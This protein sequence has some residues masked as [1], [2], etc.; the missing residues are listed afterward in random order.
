MSR[1]HPT[2]I[3]EDGATLG[4]D[5][6]IG[7]Y[8]IVGPKVVLGDGVRLHAHVV[9]EGST[10]VGDKTVIHPFAALGQP[11]QHVAHKGEDTKLIIGRENVIREHVTMHPG[12]TAGRG[13][14]VVGDK[15]L[16]MVGIH[17]AHDCIIGD[18]VIFANS[19]TLGGH[20]TVQD[21]VIL[22]GLCAVHQY[23]RIGR[24]SFVGGLAGLEGDLIPYGSCMGN[25]AHLAGLNIIGMKRRKLTRERIHNI[26]NAY[27]L[28]FAQEG[29]F[30][31]RLEDVSTLFA[32]NEAVMEIVDFIRA[33][34]NRPLC[35]PRDRA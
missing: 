29:T 23:S 18:N 35:L 13:Q 7:P 4:A 1:I 14:T 34:G 3:V 9:I 5:V 11:P 15:G 19:A 22:G 16:F 27:R 31:E 30:Q 6:E 28:L 12:T 21:Y 20:V 33:G 2:A 10:T 25:R 8:C 32:D 17:I 26:R 24:Y